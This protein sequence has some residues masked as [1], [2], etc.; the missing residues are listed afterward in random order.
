MRGATEGH[1]HLA[2]DDVE[3]YNAG[4]FWTM[5]RT[6]RGTWQAPGRRSPIGTDGPECGVE[7]SE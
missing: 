4:G 3:N 7:N 2:L 5:L 6:D 1:R